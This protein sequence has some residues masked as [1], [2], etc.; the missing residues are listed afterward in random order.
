[1]TVNLDIDPEV[2]N[3]ATQLAESSGRSVGAV[4]SE[5]AKKGLGQEKPS[6]GVQPRVVRIEKR[7]GLPVAVIDPPPPPIDPEVV[8][9]ELEENGF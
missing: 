6:E 8:R 7:N 4:V 2:L 3:A 5:L 1:M 9:R